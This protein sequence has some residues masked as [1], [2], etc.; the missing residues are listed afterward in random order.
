MLAAGT[1][2][3]VTAL[4]LVGPPVAAAETGQ[5]PDA[6]SENTV[7]Q[8]EALQSIK[9]SQ[10]AGESKVDS[11]LLVEQKLRAQRMSAS[12]V[13][14]LG[15]GANVSAAGTV[16]V[17]IRGQVSDELLKSLR[18]SGAGI[19]AVSAR[20]GSVRAEV[21]LNAVPAIAGRADVKKVETANEAFTARQLAEPAGQQAKR[22]SKEEKAARIEGELKKAVEAKGQVGA[23]AGPITSE[24]DRA[25]NADTARRQFGVTGVGTKICA[26]SDGINSLA[27]SQARGELPA[28]IDVIPGQEGDGDEG[29]AML[30]II[31]D[32]APNAS[33]G[34]ASAFNSD[35]SFADNIR[36]LRFDAGCDV[37]VDDVLYFKESP[38][39]DWIIAQAVNDVTADGA[40]YF[41]SAGN[42]GNVADGTSGHWEGD[43]VDSGKSVGKYAGTAHNFAGP[44]GNQ[45]FEPISNASSA[46]VPVTLFWSDPL[47]ASN[48]DYDLYLLNAAGNVV[49]FSQDNQTG[50]Q[51]PYERVD[52]PAAG[53]TGLRL[54]IVKFSGEGRYLSLSALRGRFS[55]SADGLK[56]Y[57]SPGVTVGH[58]AARAAFSVAA[59]PAAK[60]FPRA[61]E[62]GDPANPAGP[63]P[64][65][66]GATTKVERF[67]SDGPRRMFYQAD[68]TP[69]TPG[70]VSGTGGEVRAKPDIT[71]A[72]GVSTSVSGFTT[73]YGTSAAAPHAAAIAGLVLS[74]NPGLP[75][76]EV[77]EALVD[78][79]VDILTPGRDNSSGAGVIL[80]DKV[81][82]Y[83]G[84]SPQPLA[85]AG[86]PTVT[87]ADG[88]S[89][90]D[91]G[92]TA[93]VTLPVTN[94]GDGTATS[95]SVVLTSPTP[96]V[97][98]A[99]RSKSYGTISPGQ[100]G[101]NDFT[102]TVPATQELGVPVVLNAR[103]T[104][105]GSF[106]PTT[107]TFSL[108]VGTP[109]PVTRNFA[110]AG[111]AV[112][113]P[114]SDPTGVTVPIAVSGVGRASKVTFSVDGTTCGTDE[115]SET[116]G[117]NHS[118]VGDLV[119]TL[120]SPSGAKAT[121]FQRGGGSGNNL[122][123]VVFTDT[124][125]APFSSVAAANAPFT[126][127]YKPVQA[128]GGLI[129][130]VAADGTWTF[131]A[132][133]AAGG[134]T[135]S[136]RS[137][138][139][140]INGFVQAGAAERPAGV[141]KSVGR[142]PVKPV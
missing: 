44:A 2:A 107:S 11:R 94:R 35:A 142:G 45:I 119:G 76:A 60:A 81:L 10:H 47:G 42:E 62:P 29:T 125:A 72:D 23:A 127:T 14:A 16:L 117:I 95:T 91:P 92:D 123:Q 121:L 31:H 101:V 61:L 87:P 43:F 53:G 96:G 108:P 115:K 1:A 134:D 22:E 98:V 109:S 75:P 135:G 46:R 54:A 21:P 86:Q 24:G 4:G 137:V 85:Q 132:M 38:F 13:P 63:F 66:F 39:Q 7:R 99:P 74:G 67:T 90:L 33:L 110:Y 48:N 65:T 118:Y 32:V 93:K 17:D 136:V 30:E 26:L 113:I 59:A 122:C 103:V 129:S 100:T 18:E 57:T 41:S 40:L 140:H 126:G 20:Y 106:S 102:I 49:D 52:T 120:T 124:A 25:H 89:A 128:L 130:G 68:G 116:V 56:A 112:A 50:T 73:F 37:I 111:A 138:S 36:K 5:S 77:R 12:A 27:V 105:A 84:A 71:A 70:N 104:F 28:G 55:D 88:G 79:A 139:L 6:F 34:F 9:K 3:I 131:T 78:T 133:D 83:T 80:A 141:G 82:A 114:D 8:I 64:G 97:T 69:I 15:S 19:R 58:S 51:D